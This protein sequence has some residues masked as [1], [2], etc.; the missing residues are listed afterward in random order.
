MYR[1]L[2]DFQKDWTVE[3]EMTQR[4]MAAL[5]N[6]SLDQFVAPDGRS[7][8]FIAWHI[9]Q[10][11]PAMMGQAGLAIA[12][13]GHKGE[14]P[15]SAMDIVAAYEHTSRSLLDNVLTNWTDDILTEETPMYGGSW[16]RGQTLLYLILH[17]THHRGQMTVLMRQAGLGV[18]GTYGPSREEWSTMGMQ[19]MK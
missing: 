18:P 14:Q 13:P 4:I 9:V 6:E 5:T 1:L 16:A 12:E 11:I 10:A 2:Q 15:T 7:L 8:G 19:P 17:Q 3:S